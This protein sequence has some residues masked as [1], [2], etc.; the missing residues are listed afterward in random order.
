MHGCVRGVSRYIMAR[1]E[2]SVRCYCLQYALASRRSAAAGIAWYVGGLR[3]SIPKV[4]IRCITCTAHAS[5]PH[6]TYAW[7]HRV[8]ING[9][10]HLTMPRNGRTPSDLTC[11]ALHSCASLIQSVDRKLHGMNVSPFHCLTHAYAALRWCSV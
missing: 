1:C 2:A 3:K 11:Q 7:L 10:K 8:A 5:R 9:P 4:Y 6:F